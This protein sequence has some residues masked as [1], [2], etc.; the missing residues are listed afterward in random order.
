MK[1]G[2]LTITAAVEAVTEVAAAARVFTVMAVISDIDCSR[3]CHV[4]WSR[5][6]IRVLSAR[7]LGAVPKVSGGLSITGHKRPA[8]R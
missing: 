2:V 4:T 3:L 5:K 8:R 7:F 6:R 1:G